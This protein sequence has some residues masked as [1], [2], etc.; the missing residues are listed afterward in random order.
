VL[1][2]RILLSMVWTSFWALVFSDGCFI[3]SKY[4]CLNM[5][6]HIENRPCFALLMAMVRWD[7]GTPLLI[8]W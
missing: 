1:I 7:T 2:T 5:R 3:Q 8:S 4:L 6:F